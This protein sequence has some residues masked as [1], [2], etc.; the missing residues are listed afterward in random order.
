MNRMPSLHGDSIESDCV[1]SCRLLTVRDYSVQ[2]QPGKEAAEWLAF[3][4]TRRF[5]RASVHS[6]DIRDARVTP[7]LYIPGAAPGSRGNSGGYR[8][9]I[10]SETALLANQEEAPNSS[11]GNRWLYPYT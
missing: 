4:K 9:R 6:Q 2:V 8:S 5:W 10:C 11:R 1:M 7:L 3:R